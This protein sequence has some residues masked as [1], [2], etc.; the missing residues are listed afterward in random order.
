MLM[1][2]LD[3]HNCIVYSAGGILGAG[4]APLVIDHQTRLLVGESG[5][6]LV[7]VTPLNRNRNSKTGSLGPFV[8]KYSNRPML[9]FAKGTND[10]MM[11]ESQGFDGTINLNQR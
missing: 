2:V 11:E 9:S 3:C 5:L 10:S 6:E 7:S 1:M 4:F 8:D